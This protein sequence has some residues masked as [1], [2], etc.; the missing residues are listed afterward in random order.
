MAVN[1]TLLVYMWFKKNRFL[2]VLI[3][4]SYVVRINS[5]CHTLLFTPLKRAFLDES[6]DV[7]YINFYYVD[8]WVN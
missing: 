8:S 2:Y 6:N 1:K 4:N 7:N 3:A 5:A